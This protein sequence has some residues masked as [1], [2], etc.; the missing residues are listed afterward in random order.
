MNVRLIEGD[1]RIAATNGKVVIMRGP[2]VYCFEETDNKSYFT[3]AGN[4]YLLNSGLKAEYKGDLLGGVVC[5]KGTASFP[6]K[7]EGIS[8]TAIPYFAWCNREQGQMKV[9]LPYERHESHTGWANSF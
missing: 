1:H 7:K 3:D 4:G 8:I 5:I 9:W 2:M 6:G